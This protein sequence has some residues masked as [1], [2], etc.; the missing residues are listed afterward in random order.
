M[1][2]RNYLYASKPL[3]A[4]VL[5]SWLTACNLS[6]GQHPKAR[7]ANGPVKYGGVFHVNE[8]EYFRSLFPQNVTETVGHRITNQLYEGLVVLS[9]ADLSLHPNLATH[10]EVEDS[11]RLF[12]FHL[13]KGVFFH[14]DP[15][16][17]NG[18]GRE[19]NASDVVYC[20]EKL[21]TP[22]ASN[23]GFWLFK[24]LVEGASEFYAQHEAG[25]AQMQHVP[26]IQQINDSTVSIRLVRPFAGFL[27]R[28]AMPFTAIFPKEAVTF[29]GMDL[30]EH[31]VGTGPFCIRKIMPDA[32]VFLVRNENYWGADSFGNKLPYLDAIRWSFI[33]EEKVEML[34]FKK[35]NLEMKYRL[36]LDMVTQVVQNGQLQGEYRKFQLQTVPELSTQ[37]YGLLHTG[38]LFSNV[39]LRRAINFAIDREKIVRYTLKG[40][41]VA[42]KA[43]I[44][45]EGMPGYNY[46]NVHGFTF[47]PAQAQKELALAGYK[48]GKDFPALT[49]HINS[50]GGRNEKV[51]EAITSML[52]ENLNINVDISQSLWAQHTENSEMGRFDFWRLG[53]VAD[54][55]DPENF[56]NLCYGKNVPAD[57]ERAYINSFRYRNPVYDA[58]FEKAMAT[59]DFEARNR[60]YEQLTQMTIDDA[61]TL[62]IF[63]SLNRRLLQ[64]YVRNFPAN[65]ME[66]RL[67]REVWLDKSG[68]MKV[69]R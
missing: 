55:P 47:D 2:F 39:H 65:G 28:L 43:G 25:N 62:N 3:A 26:G 46:A 34:E 57:G 7:K 10:W 44:V 6:S 17:K 41:G 60:L 31:A 56:L 45:P 38:K 40:E 5:V 63:Y 35:G 13:R 24:D 66:Q 52:K 18:K 50:G 12:V 4:L 54:Y 48:D 8:T 23:Q 30:R 64:P 37:Y 33:K 53:W 14:N 58:L 19:M 21:C 67:F 9:Q 11:A 27:F 1:R 29:Y 61:V 68:E 32:G 51:A 69:E 59:S 36:P 49:L 22:D 15:C 16:F 42:V 20:F